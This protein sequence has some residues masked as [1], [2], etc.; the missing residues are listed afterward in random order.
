M[1]PL[2]GCTGWLSLTRVFLCSVLNVGPERGEKCEHC[3]SVE[4]ECGELCGMN[5]GEH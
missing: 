4:R 2:T 5:R 1:R 3:P